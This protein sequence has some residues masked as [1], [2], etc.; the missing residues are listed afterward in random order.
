M[1]FGCA[2]RLETWLCA[3]PPRHQGRRVRASMLQDA[4]DVQ[5]DEHMR[6]PRLEARAQFPGVRPCGPL[7]LQP[8]RPPEAAPRFRGGSQPSVVYL[9]PADKYHRFTRR[10][11]KE[12]KVL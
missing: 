8:A 11:S 7:R 10:L 5:R 3:P 9:S 1:V 6:H 12:Q 2:V 4:L